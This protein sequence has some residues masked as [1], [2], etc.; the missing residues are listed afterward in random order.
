MSRFPTPGPGLCDTCAAMRPVVTSRGRTFVLCDHARVDPRFPKYPVLPVRTC[1]AHRP[2]HAVVSW[3]GGKDACVALH[4]VRE[5]LSLIGA[6][7][8]M[9]DSGDRSRS[10]GLRAEV[11]RAQ[12][13]ALG[14][15][16][17]TR[18]CDWDSY[19]SAFADA[20]REAQRAGARQ[21]V[22]GDILY[23]EHQAWV[24]GMCA[25]AGLVAVEPIFGVA[26]LHVYREFLRLGGIARIV[27]VQASKL[28][29][30]WLFRQLDEP[31]L[32]EFAR[33]GV[34]PCGENGEYHTL[35]T[36]CPAFAAP[37]EV[38]P[39]ELVQHRGYWAVDVLLHNA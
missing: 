20:L 35:V 7:T 8:M 16:W 25:G 4:R 13:A 38:I 2:A 5:R 22:C 37:I 14:L 39:G 10:H 33:L 24:A 19:E 29:P 6:V 18:R 21:L 32:A 3:S 11:V 28:G 27:A 23:P 12:V 31:A 1:A 36:N 30:E 9:D 17:I 26:T 34:D 15:N